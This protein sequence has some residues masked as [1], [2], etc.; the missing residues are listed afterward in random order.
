MEQNYEEAK[1]FYNRTIYLYKIT[2]KNNKISELDGLVKLNY[3]KILNESFI[4]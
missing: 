2:N 4:S 3:P 1:E